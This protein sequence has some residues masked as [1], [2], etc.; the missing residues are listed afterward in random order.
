LNA[1]D[2]NTDIASVRRQAAAGGLRFAAYL[3]PSLAEWVLSLSNRRSS[4]RLQL[5]KKMEEPRAEP[6]V[7]DK[8]LDRPLL[9]ED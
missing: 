5:R 3:P 2:N 9:P 6:A 4:T 8:S 1:P 7:W